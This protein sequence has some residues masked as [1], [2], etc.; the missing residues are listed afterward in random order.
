MATLSSFSSHPSSNPSSNFVSP[1]LQPFLEHQGSQPDPAPDDYPPYDAVPD[2]DSREFSST[3]N[4]SAIANRN[5]DPIKLL[6]VSFNQ[7]HGCFAIGT[8]RGFRIYNCDPFREIFRRDFD[9][10]G[11]VGAVEMLFPVQHPCFSRR[12]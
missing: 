1:M 9:G 7:D 11:G 8:D 5:N 3:T 4:N 6:H 2:D 12:R 10:N